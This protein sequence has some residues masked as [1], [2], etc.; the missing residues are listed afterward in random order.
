MTIEVVDYL[1][2]DDGKPVSGLWASQYKIQ[3]AIAEFSS[4]QIQGTIL[5]ELLHVDASNHNWSLGIQLL[6]AYGSQNHSEIY[7]FEANYVSHIEGF[8]YL[9][10]NGNLT[11]DL[12]SLDRLSWRN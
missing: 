6:Y 1:Y 4:A 10:P 2:D 8:Q 7:P 11:N 5:H 12:P 3:I 9:S